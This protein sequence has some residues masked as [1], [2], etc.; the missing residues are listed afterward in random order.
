MKM[1]PLAALVGVM[2]CRRYRYV[3]M[4]PLLRIVRGVNKEDAFVL[5]LVTG[6]LCL[7]IWLSRVIVGVIVSALVFWHWKTCHTYIAK[8][9]YR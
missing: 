6:S 5:F 8:N 2:F 3:R 4:G 1:V 9:A 7:A